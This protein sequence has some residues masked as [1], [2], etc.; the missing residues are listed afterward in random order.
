MSPGS[1][2]NNVLSALAISEDD[3]ATWTPLRP[4]DEPGYTSIVT[5]SSMVRLKDGR[6]MALQHFHDGGFLQL[7]KMLS[8]DGG[9]S[10]SSPVQITD[11]SPTTLREPGAVR[12]PDGN[13]IAVMLRDNRWEHNK[14]WAICSDDEGESWS[15]PFLLS[16][17]LT[18]HRHVACYAPDGRLAVTFRDMA[19]ESPTRGDWIVWVGTYEDV[20]NGKEG[21]YRVR[22]TDNPLSFT[23][24]LHHNSNANR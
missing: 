5:G 4:I 20:V 21:Q 15:K 11:H 12:S 9:L 13:Q 24:M 19:Y 8:E 2:W 1:T 17:A 7:Y 14:S 6:H 10:W 23:R 16:P 18:G 3:G 22:L